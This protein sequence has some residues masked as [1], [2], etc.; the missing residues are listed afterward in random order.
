MVI[1][2]AI[3]LKILIGVL[4]GIIILPALSY[5]ILILIGLVECLFNWFDSLF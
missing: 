3:E 2:M 1:I 4:L 5:W